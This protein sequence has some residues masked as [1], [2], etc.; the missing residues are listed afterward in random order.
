MCK[1][2]YPLGMLFF[3]FA[4]PKRCSSY[5]GV[6]ELMH[7]MGRSPVRLTAR[8]HAP[9]PKGALEASWQ[10]P[11]ETCIQ[12]SLIAPQSCLPPI[13]IELL[14]RSYYTQ[15]HGRENLMSVEERESERRR[16]AP[17]P[18]LNSFYVRLSGSPNRTPSMSRHC[19]P[20]PMFAGPVST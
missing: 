10:G 9:F 11:K 17:S 16:T 3:L 12:K 5:A 20:R 13:S 15:T 8:P 14:E 18:S 7:P 4:P 1:V 6:T 19:D 2:R